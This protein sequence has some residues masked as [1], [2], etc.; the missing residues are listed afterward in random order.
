MVAANSVRSW[1]TERGV[2]NDPYV[3]KVLPALVNRKNLPMWAS[4]P[5]FE[6]LPHPEVQVNSRLSAINSFLTSVRNVAVFIPVALTWIAVS[7]AT[8]AFSAYSRATTKGTVNFLD[9]WQNGYGF[10]SHYWAIGEVALLDFVIIVF[11]I[12]LTLGTGMLST[13]LEAA[14]AKEQQILDTER[15][16]VAL[17]LSEYLFDKQ[18]VTDISLNQ[19]L[20]KVLRDLLNTTESL[21]SSTKNLSRTVKEIP[22]GK[23]ILAEIRKIKVNITGRKND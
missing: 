16:N 9:F 7:R 2:L 23:E 4:L 11:V 14:F 19:G 22:T 15:T 8:T 3:S 5:P 13:R 17:E 1:A 21:E 10:L 6:F 20:A 12:F 18:R